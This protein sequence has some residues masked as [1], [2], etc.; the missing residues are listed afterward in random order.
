MSIDVCYVFSNG[1]GTRMILQSGVVPHLRS[2]GISLS[3]IHISEP[4]RPY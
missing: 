4:T 2:L 1:F 3:L